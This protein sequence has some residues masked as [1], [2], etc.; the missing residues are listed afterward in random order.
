MNLYF[1]G[2][3]KQLLEKITND[4]ELEIVEYVLLR[5]YLNKLLRDDRISLVAEL[6]KIEVVERILDDTIEL[7]DCYVL[8]QQMN[9][10]C[11]VKIYKLLK[12][13]EDE[14]LIIK[15]FDKISL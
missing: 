3:M 8:L 4:L 10:D 6:K 15:Y 9:L 13:S 1:G 12:D 14:E 2:N 11:S 5:N 7:L